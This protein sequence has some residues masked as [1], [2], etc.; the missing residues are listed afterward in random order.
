MALSA[1]TVW[2]V[3]TTGADTNGGGFVT[4]A[5]G[6]DY[7]QQDA[8]QFSGTDL[9]I[10]AS[11]GVTSA[12]HSFAAT[13][14]GNIIQITAGTG[15]TTGFYQII[16]VAGVIA[17][18]D[19]SPGTLASTGG[20]WA[21]GGALA[22]P[23]KAGS[24]AVANN[25]CYIK[26]GTYTVT[27][28]TANIAAGCVSWPASSGGSEALIQGYGSSR[29]DYGTRPLIQASGIST[30]TLISL[31]GTKVRVENVIVDGASLTGSKGI[32]NATNV[33]GVAYKCKAL[34]C[35]S[36]GIATF[37]AILC[38]AT[39]CA[40]TGAIGSTYCFGCWSHD[41]TI[42]GFA[43]SGTFGSANVYVG[44]VASNNTGASSDGFGFN[45]SSAS[46]ISNCVAYGNGRD[47]F[48]CGNGSTTQEPV[49]NCV[50]TNNSGFGFNVEGGSPG[51]IYVNCAGRSNTS[52]NTN[53]SSSGSFGFVT[54]SADPFT[55]AS[56]NDFSLNNT[57]G[58]GAA[59]RAA[60]ALGTFPGG[61][62]TGYID[63]GAAQHADPV[64]T[65][66]G[67]YPFAG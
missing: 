54:L 61:S 15:F 40:T 45:G 4:G 19:R 42:H 8:A 47:G 49:I 44:C 58:G 67:S 23:G 6:T 66:G 10:G 62:T 63:I 14:V 12:S 17:T 34:N 48:R 33:S 59:C 18:L 55:N 56:S 46:L 5:S 3:R 20:T 65:S 9:V 37:Q 1:N 25:K 26:S 31:A 32:A 53:T 51:A 7:S 29:N 64:A 52:G 36:G 30:F 16:S 43:P 24:G 39:G 13:D 11:N 2:E 27:S 41:N 22:S 50:A 38:E 57:A 35:K 60:G 28:A 21:E